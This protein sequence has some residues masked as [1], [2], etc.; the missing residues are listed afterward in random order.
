MAAVG[1]AQAVQ[2]VEQARPGG[3]REAAHREHAQVP[4]TQHRGQAARQRFV[5]EQRIEV[6]RHLGHGDR[7]PARGH[8]GVQVSQRLCIVQ[9]A[10]LRHHAFEQSVE[11]FCLGDE[12]LQALAPID[13]A[14]AARLAGVL[15]D[16]ARGARP[17][18]LGWQVELRYVVAAL[19]VAAGFLEPG[20]ALLVHQPGQRLGKRRARIVRS[21]AP[22]GFDEQRPARAQAAQRVVQAR[23]DGHQF[24]G[25]G[26]VQVRAAEAR[27]ALE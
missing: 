8:A 7:L 19:E 18:F 1:E 23:G 26:A 17:R 14:L 27:G 5:G 20:A 21:L 10:D 25:G 22:F 9:P 24:A 15:V 4:R 6:H 13:A 16:Q 2:F 3:G 12:A 11:A